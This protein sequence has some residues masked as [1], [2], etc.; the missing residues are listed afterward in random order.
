MD[1][2]NLSYEKMKVSLTDFVLV[3][4]LVLSQ[5]TISGVSLSFLVFDLLAMLRF[6]SDFCQ[7]GMCLLH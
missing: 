2:I 4:E 3:S 5:K 7:D 1:P 6:D